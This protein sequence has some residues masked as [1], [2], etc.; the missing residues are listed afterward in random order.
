MATPGR[1]I[2]H[3]ESTPNFSLQH[4][5]FLVIDEADRLLAQSFQGWLRKV[6]S[7]IEAR[8]VQSTRIGD[9]VSASWRGNPVVCQKLLFSATL[10]RDPATIATLGLRQPE[11]YIQGLDATQ[12]G[13][14]F[15]LP[16][17][18]D[19][20]MIVLPSAEKPL[21]LLHLIYGLGLRRALVFCKSVDAANRLAHLLGFF[22]DAWLQDRVSAA[23]Y[24]AELPT[25]ERRRLLE[26]FQQGSVNM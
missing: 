25:A 3:L 7:H 15:A 2:D 8:P 23:V 21:G 5:R 19:Q 22:A 11:Y 16:D 12:V 13:E 9:D 20:N 1:L 6:N 10:T 14:Q 18:L 17:T 4:L 24:S 26:S